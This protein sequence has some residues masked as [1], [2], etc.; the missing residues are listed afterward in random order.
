MTTSIKPARKF[1]VSGNIILV[2]VTLLKYRERRK[3]C[4]RSDWSGNVL[5]THSFF[6]FV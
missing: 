5:Q 6:A 2:S 4:I 1:I 3:N